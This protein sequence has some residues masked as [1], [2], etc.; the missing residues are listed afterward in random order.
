V[1]KSRLDVM[2]N[3]LNL[4]VICILVI[5][6]F[7]VSGTFFIVNA[8]GDDFVLEA[9]QR[10][11][12]YGIGGTCI[13]GTHN[14]A[15]GDVDDDGINEIATGGFSYMMTNGSRA[16]LD[17][18]LKIWSYDGQKLFLEKTELWSGA[19]WVVY[20]AD[21][22]GDGKTEIITAGN[23]INNTSFVTELKVWNWDGETLKLRGTYLDIAVSAIWVSNLDGIGLPEIVTVERPLN[24]SE[25]VAKLSIWNWDSDSLILKASKSWGTGN[26]SRA[27]SV[28]AADL[29]NDDKIEIVTA[30]YDYGLRNSSGQLRVWGWDGTN[31]NLLGNSEWRMAEN[32][33]AV[34]VAGNPMGNTL[35]SN[36]KIADVDTDNIPEILTGGFTYDGSK[37]NGQLRIWNWNDTINLEA[38]QEWADYDITEI[39]AITINDVD[40]DGQLDIITSGVTAGSGGFAQNATIKEYAQLKVWSWNGHTLTLKQSKDW[41]VDEGV[42]AW[43]DGTGDL[44][45]DGKIEIVTV[46]CSYKDTLCDPNMRIWSL[47]SIATPSSTSYANIAI[48]IAVIA[49]IIAIIVFIILRRKNP[50]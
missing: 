42:C 21:A 33:Y 34:D 14:L 18:P 7:S 5:P 50:Q 35:V 9:E 41:N 11:E 47:P 8:Q 39:K 10:W 13:P 19:I 44:D 6:L 20:I 17:A 27:I 38:S 4:A 43:Q 3:C 15:V 26:D 45:N 25:A 40:G 12:T 32:T 37:V 28:A 2:R 31:I 46:G 29:N 48:A 49:T 22:D 30:G 24:A 1:I 36:V 16:T 23:G